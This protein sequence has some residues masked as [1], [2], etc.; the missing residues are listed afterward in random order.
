MESSTAFSG[1]GDVKEFIT[2][3]ELQGD[4]KNFDSKKKAQ[5]LA[6]RLNGRAFDVYLRLP[7]DQKQ[8]FEAIKGEL[9]N[10]FERGQQNREV[11]L[12]ELASRPHAAGEAPVTYAFKLLELVKLAYPK[13]D[14]PTRLEIAK[15]YFVRGLHPEMQVALKSLANFSALDVNKLAAEATR[16]HIAG[17]KISSHIDTAAAVSTVSCDAE[18]INSVADKVAEKIYA[19]NLNNR[20]GGRIG[21][22]RPSVPACSKQ[23]LLKCRSCNKTGHFVRHCPTR[24]CLAC[25][26]QGHDAWD[27]A[28]PK[29]H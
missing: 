20:S 26:N 29:Y 14:E 17:I 4:L 9:L 11:A 22:P 10:E 19:I 3:V 25:G 28:C 24:F 18:F 12:H 1:V 13:F 16:L 6:S 7:E 8:E 5:L 15:D 27:K 23:D 21:R 2:K